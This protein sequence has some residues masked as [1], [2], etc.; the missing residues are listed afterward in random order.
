MGQVGAPDSFPGIFFK[1]GSAADVAVPRHLLLPAP[2]PLLLDRATGATAGGWGTGSASRLVAARQ[3][4]LQPL[5]SG[6][7]PPPR[8]EG[9]LHPPHPE[10]ISKAGSPHQGSNFRTRDCQALHLARKA[11][12]APE[13]CI[14][15]EAREALE[16]QLLLLKSPKT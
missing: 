15:E 4:S 10:V 8:P 13:V 11:P 1:G 2:I 9:T 6:P 3:L 5:A 16:H 14:Y 12:E 7:R